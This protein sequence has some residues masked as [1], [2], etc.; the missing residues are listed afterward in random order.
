MKNVTKTRLRIND[1]DYRDAGVYQ[2]RA[3]ND[4]EEKSINLT[5][6]VRGTRYTHKICMF[7]SMYIFVLN[8]FTE[9]PT[10]EIKGDNYHKFG[11]ES[12]LN[13]T[14]G[15][16]PIPTISWWYKPCQTNQCA[17]KRISVSVCDIF[18]SRLRLLT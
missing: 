2:L 3:K 16:Y 9:K 6:V 1:V 15:G 13:C 11:E 5:L 14:A 4:Y 7:S 17:F 12:F 8:I 18:I 10:V